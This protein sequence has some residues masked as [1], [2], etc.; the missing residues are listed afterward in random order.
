MNTR[1]SRFE[2]KD[3]DNLVVD[4]FQVRTTNTGEGIDELAESIKEFGLINP[5][6]VCRSER[7]GDKWEVVC[8]QRRLYAHKKM[9]EHTIQAGVIDRVLTFDEG[10]AVSANENVHQ[11]QM[12]RPDLVDLCERLYIRY[13][14]MTA[15]AEKTK[16]PYHVV[17]KYVRLARLHG[18][19]RTMVENREVELDIAVKAQDATAGSLK[20]ALE[21]VHVLKRSDNDLRKKI[22]K[23][24]KEN[25]SMNA[26]EAEK[27]AEQAPDDVRISG[28]LYG[29]HADAIRQ[30]ALE[31]G[32]DVSTVGMDLIEDA[33]DEKG[34]VPEDD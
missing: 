19:L 10:T 27:A 3:I 30:L 6:I 18:K 29:G 14:T 1:I 24:K 17:R 20:E 33:L 22:L 32:S 23:V 5:I 13:G 11:L 25:P 12:S 31:K 2:E 4:R 21:F 15:V 16:V 9:G 26:A 8:G 28:R 34:L 7:H